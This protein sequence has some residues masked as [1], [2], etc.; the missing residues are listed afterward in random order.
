ML[1]VLALRPR[2]KEV[3]RHK[4]GAT[5]MLRR[6]EGVW[7]FGFEPRPGLEPGIPVACQLSQK[8]RRPGTPFTPLE[9]LEGAPL[10]ADL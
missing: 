3:L 1:D 5:L 8:V 9:L 7:L 10:L 2:N 4:A 6:R